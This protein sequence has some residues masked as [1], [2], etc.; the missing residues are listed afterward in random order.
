M[1]DHTM[2]DHTK[3]PPTTL[4]KQGKKS[5][6]LKKIKKFWVSS[7]TGKVRFT[8]KEA[9][10]RKWLK[11]Q[12]YY[13][14]DDFQVLKVKDNI[15]QSKTPQEVLNDVIAYIEKYNDDELMTCAL[16][17]CEEM[18]NK[19]KGILISLPL[20]PLEKYFYTKYEAL[21]PYLNGIAVITASGYYFESYKKF[22]QRNKFIY[23][24]QIIQRNFDENGNE[25]GDFAKFSSFVTND[26]K[27]LLNY[28]TTIGYLIST[29]KNPSIARAVI[30]SDIQSQIANE[31]LGRTGKGIV[32]KGL[33]HIVQTTEYNGK[34]TDLKNDKFVYQNVT[35]L[36][37]LMV[38]QD[39]SKGFVFESLFSTLT[40]SM[41]VER[42]YQ[43]KKTIDFSHS[44]KIALTTN[45]TIPQDTDS[46]K[47][48]KHLL[49][50]NNFF[51]AENKPE[52]HF[53]RMLF[54]WN[55]KEWAKFDKYMV[56]CVRL[57]LEKGL[58][59]YSDKKFERQKLI[60]QTSEEFVE[61]MESEYDI[62]N[63][64]FSIKEVANELE[65]ESE[66]DNAKSRIVGGW[67]D[68]YAAY[69]CHNVDRAK[70]GGGLTKIC[71]RP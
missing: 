23:A 68:L 21:I 7:N 37:A 71:F 9:L 14:N 60:N 44:P 51:N 64:F 41:S 28:R 39:V 65:I 47:D 26:K 8:F 15:A 33:S 10:L 29:Y 30:I 70:L 24:K 18:L 50:L 53:K 54:D 49:M 55:E 12:G 67:I 62:L 22:K 20:F 6:N 43:S 57:F 36:T 13:R 61:L 42:K 58:V 4:G 52:K 2:N 25:K 38:I 66:S 1:N 56:E 16:K 35:V 17:Q 11:Q 69:K 34:A 19:R 27:H 3:N 40:D 59:S 48:R 31:P 45:Y 32:I 46:F 63:H 5:K